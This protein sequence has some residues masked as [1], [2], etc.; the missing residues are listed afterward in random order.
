[1][2]AQPRGGVMAEAAL[3][4]QKFSYKPETGSAKK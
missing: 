4:T 1:V 3:G 2:F